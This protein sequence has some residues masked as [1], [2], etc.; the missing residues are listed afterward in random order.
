MKLKNIPGWFSNYNLF[1]VKI[2][3]IILS[4]AFIT[5][6]VLNSAV[7]SDLHAGIA[8]TKI[9]AMKRLILQKVKTIRLL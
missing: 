5:A 2:N 7:K 8:L 9:P 6:P 4:M 3:I 1:I